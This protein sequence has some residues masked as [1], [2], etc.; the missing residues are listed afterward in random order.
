MSV[1]LCL[2]AHL[3]VST[4][5]SRGQAPHGNASLDFGTGADLEQQD[6]HG[7][8]VPCAFFNRKMKKGHRVWGF[9]ERDTYA[10]VSCLS[11]FK[12]WIRARKVTVYLDNKSLDSW[13]K[14][15][16]CTMAGSFGRR[17]RWREVLSCYDIVLV[18]KLG[19]DN[20]VADRLSR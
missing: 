5:A 15:D 9:R 10:L 4:A 17:G 14:E 13:Y 20:V 7:Q 11:K 16:V 2:P 18:Y 3:C 8:W 1:V 19:K 6:E 12:S